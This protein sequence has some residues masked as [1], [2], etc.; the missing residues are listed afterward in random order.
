MNCQ[1]SRPLAELWGNLWV[2]FLALPSITLNLIGSKPESPMPFPPFLFSIAQFPGLLQRCRR[3]LAIAMLGL[4][5]TFSSLLLWATP[6]AIASLNDDHFDG[7]IFALYAGNG[8]LVPPRL[9]LAESLERDKPA[10][11]VFYV[12]D[13]K[14]C[15]Q[16]SSVISHLQAFYGRAA[17][18]IPISVDAIAPKTS[19]EPTEPG[20]YYQG[21]V[22][23]TVIIDSEGQVALN[24]SGQVSFEQVD[25]AFRI[26]FNLLPRSESTD[27]K[28]RS[29][30]V[31]E[32][33]TEIVD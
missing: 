18:F 4:L 21:F 12:D 7:N 2:V 29:I 19:Y 13:S 6:A 5:A 15:K 25:D 8:S 24:A 16:Y 11:L 27:L 17:S 32:L 30:P 26:V 1:G 9:S 23:Q 31:N 28:R 33:N 3:L 10:L 20:Y 22:P 14:D